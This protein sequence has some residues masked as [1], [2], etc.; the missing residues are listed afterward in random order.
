M[1][2][3]HKNKSIRK[4]KLFLHVKTGVERIEI[5]AVEFVLYD[6]QCFAETLEV[7]NLTHTE[8]L[9]NVADIRVLHQISFALSR[10]GL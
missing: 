10:A 2:R 4:D 7:N 6:A 1:N 3:L 5:L 9:D 8:E